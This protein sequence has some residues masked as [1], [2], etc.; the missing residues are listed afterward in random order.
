[1]VHSNH[2]IRLVGGDAAMPLRSERPP[3]FTVIVSDMFWPHIIDVTRS[4][5]HPV[6]Y[7][8]VLLGK[9]ATTTILEWPSSPF[10]LKIKHVGRAK[11]KVAQSLEL[12]VSEPQNLC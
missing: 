3:D 10:R 12:M 8:R 5:S 6:R 9:R 7:V 4:R 2:L 11:H 1:M